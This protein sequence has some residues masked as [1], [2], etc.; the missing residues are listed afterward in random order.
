MEQENVQNVTLNISDG[1]LKKVVLVKEDGTEEVLA[2]YE[3]NFKNI[4]LTFEKE[5]TEEGTY[6]IKA[7]DRNNNETTVTFTIDKT[8]ATRVYSTLDFDKSGK[9]YYEIDKEKVYYVKNGDSFV[10]R[11]Q[12]S[13]ELKTAPTVKVGGMTV[14]MTLNEKILNN[15]GKYIYEGTVNITEEAKLEEGRL[16]V[17]LSDVIDMAGNESTDE[18]VLN[19][20]PTSNARVAVYD[21]TAPSATKVQIINNSNPNS[22]YIKNGETVRVRVTFNEKL[23]AAPVLTIGNYTTTFENVG[24]GKGNDLYSADI[25]IANDESNLKEGKLAFTITGYTD[26]AGN[27]GNKVTE[28]SVKTNI[29][30]DRTAPVYRALGIYGG[31]HSGD[32]WYVT[33]GDK[34]YINV[35]FNEKLA[36]SPHVK[37]NGK[38]IFQ[39]G[40]PVEKENDKG[41]KYYIYSKV[42]NVGEQDGNLSFEIY[43]YADEAGNI[44]KTLTALN[45]TA[46]AQNGNIIVDNTMPKVSIGGSTSSKNWHKEQDIEVK[47]TEANIDNIYYAF[48]ASSNDGSMHRILDSEKAIKVDKKDIID[49][50]DGTYT[51]KIH[52]ATEG[53][54]VLNIKVV[55]KAGN[56]T[57]TRRGWYKIDRT[58]PTIVLHKDKNPEEIKP[59]V[60]NYCVSATISDKNLKSTKLNGKDYK[61]DDFICDDGNHTLVATDKAG[62]SKTIEFKIDRT[63]PV[64]TINGVNYTGDTND[65]GFFNNI[66]LKLTEVNN[67]TA[68][69]NDKEVD[70]TTYDFN[71]DGNYKVKVVDEASNNTTVKFTVD[72]I[73]VALV[74][75]RV[76][77]NNANKDVAKLGDTVGI[78]LN[79]NEE[80]KENPTFM[81][82]G[83]EYK[84]NYTD[85]YA[86]GKYLYAVT[87]QVTED[88]NDGKVEFTISNLYDKAGNKLNDLSNSDANGEV[89]IDK[90][91][92]TININNW[93]K[94]TFQIG[95]TYEDEGAT[96]TDNIDGDITDKIEVSYLYYDENG[97]RVN[98][99][100][101]EIKFDRVGEF[102]IKYIVTD[103]A[104][105]RSEKTR[106]IY[107]V[108]DNEAP[109]L[110]GVESGQTYHGSI[111]YEMSDNSGNF[112]IYYDFNN[113]Y[114]NYEDL[115]NDENAKASAIHVE[116]NE[117]NGDFPITQDFTGVSVALVDESGNV[118]FRNNITISVN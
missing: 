70:L 103:R 16:E 38:D 24:D 32:A 5:Y 108:K 101:K 86:E 51:T 111:H 81:I 89:I 116:N 4:K 54:Y 50:G 94:L 73:P 69:V 23:A 10:F 48:N 102:V 43:G 3:D 118:T 26:L 47:V 78:Y 53:R 60:H 58:E 25:T 6:T 109:I 93:K 35:H 66:D 21:N 113:N 42:Y 79:V 82:N 63:Y 7:V 40:N 97:K 64:I 27:T 46:G 44:G 112:T 55:D 84:V 62:N 49:N 9:D 85:N 96:A 95:D 30:Y 11:M 61:S 22:E 1:S 91:A 45:T 88:M 72:T 115:I 59:G 105:N 87:Y 74:E 29:I 28:D 39:Y 41:E 99:D 65:A 19:Q 75:L 2:T 31:K 20:T 68:W 100:P 106:R 117:Y 36:V 83:K 14:P 77:S 71:K 56:T 17:I 80:L 104:G 76:N 18:V 110:K 37:V 52:L 57:Y 90:T 15:E 33:N 13:E 34:V 98:P 107:I 67:Y 92:P 12:F 114:Q 8:P